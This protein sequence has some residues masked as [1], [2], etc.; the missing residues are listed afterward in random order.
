MGAELTQTEGAWEQRPLIN[1]RTLCSR[2][3]LTVLRS[4][5]TDR[6]APTTAAFARV[7]VSLGTFALTFL[8]TYVIGLVW[9]I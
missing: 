9:Q 7:F 2:L 6:G 3:F 5:E 4:A 1:Q 8:M